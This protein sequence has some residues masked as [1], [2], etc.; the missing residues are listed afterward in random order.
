M[1]MVQQAIH[2]EGLQQ[3]DGS[4]GSRLGSSNVHNVSPHSLSIESGHLNHSER[5]PDSHLQDKA[6]ASGHG[7]GR[8]SPA[9]QSS[10]LPA[11]KLAKFLAP[12]SP[13]QPEKERLEADDDLT[14][15]E[16]PVIVSAHSP[17]LSFQ[18]KHS[19]R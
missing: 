3:P 10:G 14:S 15:S 13:R 11:A 16:P 7:P 8:K 5:L 18:R 2:Q 19:Q 6:S 4:H 17:G 12:G 9:I 1:I